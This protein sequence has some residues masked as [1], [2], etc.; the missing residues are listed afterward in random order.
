MATLSPL[1]EA[2]NAVRNKE[3]IVYYQPQ[4]DAVTNKLVSAEALVRRRLPDGSIAL[5][6]SFVPAAEETDLIMEIDWNVLEQVCCFLK[7]RIDGGHRHVPIAVNF[8]R[9]HIGE[10]DFL[11]KLCRTVDG[12]GIP[13]NLIEVEITESA[14]MDGA[15]DIVSFV[16]AVRKENF[17]VAIDDF[18]SGFSSLSLVKDISAN[19][20]KIDR[21]LLSGN[22]ENEKERI[23]LESIFDFAHRLKLTTIAEGVETREQL[24]FLRTCG[25]QLIQGFLFAKP[26]PEEDFGE[27]CSR[28]V[29][30]G[31]SE[32]ILVSQAHANVRNLLMEAVFMKYPLVIMSNLTRN[33]FYM[34]A[35][36]NFS[37]RTCPSTGVFDELIVH[38]TSTMHPD[39]RELFST[40]FSRT[41][42]LAAHARGEKFVKVVTRQIGDD[43]VYRPVETTDFFVKNPSVDDVLVITLCQN[44]SE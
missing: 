37:A 20:L 30:D 36:E 24:G 43:G 26:M 40:T 14:M 19:V 22:C 23:V 16:D 10:T 8:S 6:G 34:M 38:G 44:L 39:D 18:G 13:R 9:R 35:Y 27:A 33:S 28:R 7:K 32:D 21:S 42:L 17:N 31:E 15:Y 5:P 41:N 4:Y 1:T 12:Y 2:E 11:E 3:L 25:C 29:L